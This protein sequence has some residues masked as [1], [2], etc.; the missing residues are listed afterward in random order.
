M[1]DPFVNK[2]GASAS[3][4]AFVGK[5]GPFVRKAPPLMQPPQSPTRGHADRWL[6]KTEC[7]LD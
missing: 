5:P 1:L 7:Q 3:K 2:P 6:G 4:S